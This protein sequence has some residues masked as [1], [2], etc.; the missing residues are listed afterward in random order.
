MRPLPLLTFL[1]VTGI[2]V[3][4]GAVDAVYQWFNS[5]KD[6][7]VTKF[8]EQ[9]LTVEDVKQRDQIFL[10]A[11][12]VLTFKNWQTPTQTDVLRGH[13]IGGILVSPDGYPVQWG[14]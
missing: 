11:S 5:T 8:K 12:Y 6:A 3:D 10:Y 9:G 2:S 1:L 7:C 13:N 14:L 4:A